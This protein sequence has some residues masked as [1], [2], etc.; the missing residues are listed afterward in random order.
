MPLCEMPKLHCSVSP[1]H[2][3][4]W[5]RALQYLHHPSTPPCQP[6]HAKHASPCRMAMAW[7]RIH[8]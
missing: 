2:A 7:Q 6:P 1:F 3:I 5:C 8:T 4:R